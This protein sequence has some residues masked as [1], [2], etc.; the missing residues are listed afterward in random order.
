MK[1]SIPVILIS[2]SISAA[3]AIEI[4]QVESVYNSGRISQEGLIT[5]NTINNIRYESS[6][7]G[8]AHLASFD[9]STK[10]TAEAAT[11]YQAHITNLVESIRYSG[12]LAY[13]STDLSFQGVSDSTLILHDIATGTHYECDRADHPI[14]DFDI[15]NDGIVNFLDKEMLLENRLK[16]QCDL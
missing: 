6:L 13:S 9:I 7:S 15:N 3:Q 1:K 16:R 10:T 14:V 4:G 5:S 12:V 8:G 11:A 2:L